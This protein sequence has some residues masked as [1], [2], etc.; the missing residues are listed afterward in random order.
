L[1]IDGRDRAL[2]VGAPFFACVVT[3]GKSS[4]ER[5]GLAKAVRA[6]VKKDEE[7]QKTN[8]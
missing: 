6:A 3:L 5:K 8:K 2:T 1:A 4:A 7:K